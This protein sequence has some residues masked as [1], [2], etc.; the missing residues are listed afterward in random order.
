MSGDVLTRYLKKCLLEVRQTFACVG[1]LLKKL[2][3]G[4]KTKPLGS[5]RVGPKNGQPRVTW[6]GHFIV[7]SE[8]KKC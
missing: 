8:I 3:I 4:D 7:S 1:N 5:Q 2:A 6:L